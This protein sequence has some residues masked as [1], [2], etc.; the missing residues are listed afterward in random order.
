MGPIC[1][2][3]SPPKRKEES[4]KRKCGNRS[5]S[6]C[7]A[8]TSQGMATAPRSWRKQETSSLLQSS[9]EKSPT[10]TLILAQ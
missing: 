6:Q 3:N 7:D 1:N 10:K 2:N 5:R 9:K 8:A 4:Q